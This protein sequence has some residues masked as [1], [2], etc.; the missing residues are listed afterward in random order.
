MTNILFVL[1]CI[2]NVCDSRDIGWELWSGF[3]VP[4]DH[5]FMAVQPIPYAA[6]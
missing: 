5:G 1:M 2:V 4:V 3:R 6:Q